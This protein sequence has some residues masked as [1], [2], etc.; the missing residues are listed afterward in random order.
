MLDY[1]Y[2]TISYM[3]GRPGRE[4]IYR[5]E[6]PKSELIRFAGKFPEDFVIK[7]CLEYYE[8]ETEETKKEMEYSY[9][10]F[11]ANDIYMLAADR[12]ASAG[13]VKKHNKRV[14][15]QKEEEYGLV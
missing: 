2:L 5:F 15:T 7:K 9:E 4:E 6:V 3:F 12:K 11:G 13:T 14:N 1:N 10:V 8:N